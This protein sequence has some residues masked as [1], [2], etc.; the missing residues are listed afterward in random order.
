MA[1]PIGPEMKS[2]GDLVLFSEFSFESGLFEVVFF[3]VVG[4]EG[5]Q[6]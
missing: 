3:K 6:S 1:C 4:A 5:D 2:F